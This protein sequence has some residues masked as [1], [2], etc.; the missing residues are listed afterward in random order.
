MIILLFM[1]RLVVLLTATTG[2]L[3]SSI[4][5]APGYRIS[6]MAFRA[7]AVRITQI[8]SVLFGLFNNLTIFY[9]PLLRVV[10][11]FKLRK[12]ECR[13]WLSALSSTSSLQSS[14]VCHINADCGFQPY[15]A[16]PPCSRQPF[17]ILIGTKLAHLYE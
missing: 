15:R 6:T 7:T 12:P 4:I 5:V 1:H 3:L 2:V 13:L 8:E 9:D 11:F 10:I 14:A 17:V 16:L